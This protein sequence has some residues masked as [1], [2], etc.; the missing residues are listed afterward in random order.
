MFELVEAI[1]YQQTL[2]SG[3]TKPMLLM[4]EAVTGKNETLDV[5]VKLSAGCDLREKSLMREAFAAFLA[6][7]LGLQV[8]RPFQVMLSPE[9]IKT[10]PDSG[11]RALAQRS[12]PV[13]FG[14][15]YLSNGW[16]APSS[17]LTFSPTMLNQAVEIFA[18]D[19]MIGNGDRRVS[20]PN[21]LT[22]G[23][24]IAVFDHEMAFSHF[25]VMPFARTY[26]WDSGSL[27]WQE[28]HV[29]LSRLKGKPSN[30]SRLRDAMEALAPSRFAEYAS[31]IPPDWRPSEHIAELVDYLKQL[32]Q[33]VGPTLGEVSRVLA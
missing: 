22:N 3:R 26:P 25:E 7:D 30:V 17:S 32:Q 13:A 8:P 28:P 16:A 21:C 14:S 15:L 6:A 9:L 29:F 31:A 12:C 24:A 23:A 33:N 19:A 27:Q 4:C 5:V 2:S 20:K 10:I 18:F 11:A 1:S